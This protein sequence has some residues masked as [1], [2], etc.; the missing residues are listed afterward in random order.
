MSPFGP[1]EAHDLL[2]RAFAPWVQA[3]QLRAVRFDADGG[4]FV[5]P[6]S[7][8]VCRAA[9]DGPPI[10]CGQA[11]AAAADTVSVLALSALNGRYRNLTTV[12]LTCHFLRP[13]GL[14]DTAIRL[15]ALSN[16]RRMAT[17]RAEFRP[18]A[19]GKLGATVTCAF[20]YLED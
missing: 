8:A 19:G 1:D 11:I 7:E 10:L 4:D 18:A 5:L 20:A 2:R 6:A 14:G 3:L 15:T 16:G 13:L 17:T 12:D 9:P